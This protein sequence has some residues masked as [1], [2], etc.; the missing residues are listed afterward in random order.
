MMFVW[1][2]CG[3]YITNNIY[4]RQYILF[5]HRNIQNLNRVKNNIICLI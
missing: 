5:L 2:S 4:L 3:I 1:G